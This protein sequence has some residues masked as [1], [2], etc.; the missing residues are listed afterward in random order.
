MIRV[1]QIG[2]DHY[3][4]VKGSRCEK[5]FVMYLDGK[6]SWT[7][8]RYNAHYFKSYGAAK[9]TMYALRDIARKL[10]KPE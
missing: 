9:S 8:R 5:W 7:I 2:L 10:E 3:G 1:Q 4:V 6:P